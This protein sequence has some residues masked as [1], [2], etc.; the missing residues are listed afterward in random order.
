[1]NE[2]VATLALQ[3]ATKAIQ[4]VSRLRAEV[5]T[6][7][8]IQEQLNKMAPAKDGINGIDGTSGTRGA[9]GL[10]GSNGSNGINGLDGTNGQVGEVGPMPKH[11]IK[12][13]MIRFEVSEGTFGNWIEVGGSSGGGGGGIDEMRYAI[14]TYLKDVQLN[15]KHGTVLGDATSSSLTFTLPRSKSMEG[16]VLTIKKVDSSAN[17]VTIEGYKT[18]TI[19]GDLTQVICFQWT[20]LR[21]QSNGNN[22]VI[23]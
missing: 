1:M 8:T 22:W 16:R 11:E 14:H 18:E 10:N 13:N 12:G 15:D 17:T 2:E 9:D 21:L 6:L 7:D 4:E 19:D 20:S 5:T 3:M 23:L